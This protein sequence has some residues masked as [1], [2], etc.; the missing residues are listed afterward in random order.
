MIL[1]Q[2]SDTHRF[3][4]AEISVLGV[5]HRR[6]AQDPDGRGGLEIAEGNNFYTEEGKLTY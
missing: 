3:A 5:R 6:K 4:V 1:K 2:D